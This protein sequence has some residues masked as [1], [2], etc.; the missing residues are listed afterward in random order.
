MQDEAKE[1]LTKYGKNELPQKKKTP[2][3]V[4]FLKQFCDIMIVI[5]LIAAVVSITMA[6]IQKT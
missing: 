6:I 3:I 2:N 5:L 4:K 1:R